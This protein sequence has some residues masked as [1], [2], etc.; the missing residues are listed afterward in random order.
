LRGDK[1]KEI[2]NLKEAIKTLE[3]ISTHVAEKMQQLWKSG[4]IHQNHIAEKQMLLRVVRYL[5][6]L[7]QA[8]D[9][10]FAESVKVPRFYRSGKDK[11]TAAE[12]TTGAIETLAP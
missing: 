12:D 9:K 6:T 4:L 2:D 5:E 10:D 11:L 7:Q 3:D 1:P 8:A